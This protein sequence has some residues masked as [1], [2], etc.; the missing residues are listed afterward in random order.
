MIVSGKI[1]QVP[2]DN[3]MTFAPRLCAFSALTCISRCYFRYDIF[4]PLIRELVHVDLF[5]VR[6]NCGYKDSVIDH[7]SRLVCSP[8]LFEAHGKGT[9]VERVDRQGV[10]K[11]WFWSWCCGVVG[12]QDG[13][14]HTLVY[15]AQ[16]PYSQRV[17]TAV[18]DGSRPVR[19]CNV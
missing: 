7:C 19:L 2:C 14:E 10:Q 4:Q 15:N 11:P 18:A 13:G 17:V 1:Y 12:G 3:C 5:I 9:E 8:H 6:G 16:L